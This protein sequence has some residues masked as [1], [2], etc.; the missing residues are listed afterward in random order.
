MSTV[1]IGNTV[2]IHYTGTL[3]NGT[4][5]DSSRNRDALRFEVGAGQVIPGFE[6]AVVGMTEGESKE[7]TIPSDEAYGKQNDAA[8]QEIPKNRF[9]DGFEGTVG[10]TVTGKNATGQDFAATIISEQEETVTL[11]FN[12]PLAGEDLT[13]QVELVSI[14]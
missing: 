13:F 11:D 9:P 7:F 10:E 4:E 1:E 6:T 14:A 2:I 5:F 3:N 8:V 12:H